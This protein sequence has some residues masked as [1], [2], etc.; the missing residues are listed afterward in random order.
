MNKKK[1]NLGIEVLRMILCFWVITFHCSGLNKKYKI[2]NTF[3]HVPTFMLITF[4]LSYRIVFSKEIQ[5]LKIRFCR[6]LLPYIIIPIIYLL[7]LILKFRK[8]S[9]LKINNL[10]IDLYLQYLT[11]YKLYISLWFVENLIIF[12]IFFRIIYYS[13]KLDYFFIL[14]LIQI[15]SYL[16]QYNEINIYLSKYKPHIRSFYL[17]IEMLPIAIT[18]IMFAHIELLEQ[19]KNH[20]NKSIFFS[21]FILYFIYKYNVFVNVNG[22]AYSG[23]KNNIAAIC[24][25]ISF[26][27][28][29][30]DKLMNNFILIIVK[31]LTSHTG[32]IYYFH[33]IIFNLIKDISFLK[34][35]PILRCLVIYILGYIYI[36]R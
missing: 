16:L 27:L 9:I 36:C 18:G 13:F 2:L 30:F 29:P 24:L 4:Y 8:Y 15:F 35:S 34:I 20:R 23:I 12:S 26:S 3:F 11:G 1:I 32:G 6:L 22:F 31:K 28:I 10:F 17:I 7:V 5:K 25:F 21:L 14:Q 19:L 33:I